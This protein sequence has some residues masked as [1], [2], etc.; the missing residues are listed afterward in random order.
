[1]SK[2]K[3]IDISH[4]Q[5]GININNIAADFVIIKATQGTTKRDECFASYAKDILASNKLFGIYHFADGKSTGKA[6]AEWFC[7][8]VK[9]YVGKALLILDWEA[10]A[11]KKGY[12][13]AKEFCDTVVKKTKVKPIIY[14]S[15]I[16]FKSY[17]WYDMSYFYPYMWVAE[18]G[19]NPKRNVYCLD[20]TYSS[21]TNKGFTEIIRQYSSNTYLQGYK[22]VLDA[23]VAFIDSNTWNSLCKPNA[24]NIVK[25]TPE[26]IKDVVNKI[27]NKI[28]E[29]NVNGTARKNKLIDNG[30]DPVEVQN[31]INKILKEKQSIKYYTVKSGD[32]ATKIAKQ[33]NITLKKL[34]ELN[35]DITNI[36]KLR[37]RQ[38]VRVK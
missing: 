16:V 23:N 20:N 15:A 7:K 6:E 27:I 36:N 32:T 33:Y 4:W 29:W 37:V 10:D 12:E 21:R 11:L 5:K 22:G 8:I 31:E 24:T 9:P 38:K 1:M 28:G 13:Y 3:G 19:S 30:F 2:L 26:E 18:Y 14:C 35:P 17:Q 34:Q 25:K